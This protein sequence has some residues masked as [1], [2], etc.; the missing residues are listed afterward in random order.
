[1]APLELPLLS[2]VRRSEVLANQQR[3]RSEVLKLQN[4]DTDMRL[5]AITEL[6]TLTANPVLA[7]I[8][9]ERLSALVRH[10][11]PA[12]SQAVRSAMLSLLRRLAEQGQSAAIAFETAGILECLSPAE[13]PAVQR[14]AAVLLRVVAEE[15]SANILA[16]HVSTLVNCFE[17]SSCS[18]VAPLD[19]LS[20]IAE[21]GETAAVA[22]QCPRLLKMLDHESARARSAICQTLSAAC[23]DGGESLRRLGLIERRL[24]NEE[25]AD[26]ELKKAL[27]LESLLSVAYS[28]TDNNVRLEA[29][30]ALKAVVKSNSDFAQVMQD[31]FSLLLFR[32]FRNFGERRQME[33]RIIFGNILGI[34]EAPDEWCPPKSASEEAPVVG[35]CA[36]CLENIHERPGCK[37]ALPCSHAF[38]DACIDSW[39]RCQVKLGRKRTCPL[40]RWTEPVKELPTSRLPPGSS[41]TQQS[42]LSGRGRQRTVPRRLPATRTRSDSR[43]TRARV[44]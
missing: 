31:R 36:I 23:C 30:R 28:D 11:K 2:P 9:V 26:E 27:L 22:E 15:G 39:F 21:K 7:D 5:A 43:S 44:R 29:A 3:V 16:K 1:M 34:D 40:C 12:E 38:H 8:A 41:A 18:L 10:L 33:L 37:Q 6:L 20:A 32:G 35:T 13:D 42:S 25:A 4:G 19:A 24:G 14:K 17:T